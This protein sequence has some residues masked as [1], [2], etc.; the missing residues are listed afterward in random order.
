MET[1]KKEL[2]AHMQQLIAKIEA[3]QKRFGITPL[4]DMLKNKDAYDDFHPI[5]AMI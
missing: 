4:A 1:N 3:E 5:H 2:P